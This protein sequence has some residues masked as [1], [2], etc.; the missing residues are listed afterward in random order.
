MVTIRNEMHGGIAAR[1]DLLD[2]VWGAARFEKTGRAAARR[3]QPRC[4]TV[5]HRRARRTARR[6]GAALAPSAPVRDGRPLLLGPLAVDAAQRRPRRRRCID[7]ARHGGSPPARRIARSFWSATL[8]I[9]GAS[10]S[11]PRRWARCGC[12]GPASGI[13]CLAASSIPGALDGARGLIGATGRAMPKPSFD[14]PRSPASR[15]KLPRAARRL[16]SSNCREEQ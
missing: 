16:V 5:A 6:H 12:R 2:R 9:T 13:G 14:A 3:P 7:A 10:A 11:R 8:P 1:E 4:G 15:G